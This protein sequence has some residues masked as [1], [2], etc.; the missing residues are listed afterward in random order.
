MINASPFERDKDE[1]RLPLV[2]RRAVETDTIVAY[3]NIVGGQDDLVFD[4]DSVV[5]D[6]RAR[7]SL[8]RPSSRRTSW[9]SIS[10]L[11]AAHPTPSPDN[12]AR[13]EIPARRRGTRWTLYRPMSRSRRTTANSSGTRSYWGCAITLRRTDSPR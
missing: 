3:V 13:V 8:A 9:W 5:V 1:V 4:G 7:S 12:V 11:D 6:P 10:T 2:T